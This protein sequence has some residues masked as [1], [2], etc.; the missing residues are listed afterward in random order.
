MFERRFGLDVRKFVFRKRLSNNWSSVTA[1]RV[2][3]STV[4]TFKKYF[5]VAVEQEIKK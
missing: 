2:N 4:N 5:S 1:K 3:C